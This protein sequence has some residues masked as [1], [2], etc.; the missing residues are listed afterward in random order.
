MARE[1]TLPDLGEGIHE[2]EIQEILVSAGDTVEEGETIL[3]VETDK[4]AVEVPSPFTGSV[5]EISVEPGALVN[6][7]DR[8]IT[9][10][11]GTDGDAE[12]GEAPAKEET[13]E[14]TKAD[15]SAEDGEKAKKT[16]AQTEPVAASPAT[17]RLA[18]ELEVD[19]DQV[20]GSGPGGRVT[21]EDVRAFAE[22][23]A[24][25]KKAEEA[26]RPSPTE[27]AKES[28]VDTETMPSVTAPSLPD[29]G[30]WG[31]VRRE[32]LRSVRRTTA[33]RMAQSWSHI[34]HVSHED[35]ADVTEL[36]QLR[37]VYKK[38]TETNSLSLTVFVL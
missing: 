29:F 19:L 13:V 26:K 36:E 21:A 28:G 5:Q 7:G 6:V 33:K 17:R 12:K 16:T 30:R 14:E 20:P 2:A 9:F 23:D 31:E 27:E 15:E 11:N 25:K 38:E 37:Q 3:L 10:G 1:F 35:V 32:P 18:R 34:P 4:A 8:I 22:D 24:K